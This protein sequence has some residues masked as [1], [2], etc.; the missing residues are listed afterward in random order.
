MTITHDEARVKRRP[1]YDITKHD[2]AIDGHQ[3]AIKSVPGVGSV[4]VCL[5]C[6]R[7]YREPETWRPIDSAPRDGTRI[8][9]LREHYGEMRVDVAKWDDD[10]Y[11]KKPRP[12]WSYDQDACGVSSMR[13]NQPTHWMPLPSTEV[14]C[15]R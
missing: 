6:E 1:D 9:I 8:L 3:A 7:P 5:H 10:Q 4:A 2:C 15:V 14:P 13:A 12:Y 11:A